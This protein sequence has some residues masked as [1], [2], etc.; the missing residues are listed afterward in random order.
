[1][2]KNSKIEDKKKKKMKQKKKKKKLGKAIAPEKVLCCRERFR[3]G[4]HEKTN[5]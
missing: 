1:M 4:K 5:G 3:L 2:P